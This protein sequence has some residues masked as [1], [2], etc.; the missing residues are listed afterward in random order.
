MAAV[1]VPPAALLAAGAFPL[2][3]AVRAA[4]R[5]F[6][7][8]DCAIELDRLLGLEERL[9]TAVEGAGA[10]RDLQ[11]AEA[12]AAFARAKLPPRR[13]P[14]EARFLAG[15]LVLL[16]AL[17]A[18][19]ASGPAGGRAAEDEALRAVLE[20]E[21]ARLEAV[22]E[23]GPVEFRE[24]AELLRGGRAEAALDRLEAMREKLEARLLA[25]SAGPGREEAERLRDAAGAAAEALAARLGRLSRRS[26]AARAPEAAAARLG[27]QREHFETS[28][29]EG[30]G[31][32]VPAAAPP[33]PAVRSGRPD[34]DPKYDAVI[35]R[36]FRSVP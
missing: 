33:G 4:V 20:A 5:R 29:P 6:S 36:Y 23:S 30:G 19:P 8:R 32:A 21:A 15:S 16:A 22:A 27:F 14:R 35:R 25:E 3:L 11:A 24:A 34:W 17:L 2:A 13:L 9:A 7:L 31:P 12:A 28:E 18:V 26:P 10:F 1:E